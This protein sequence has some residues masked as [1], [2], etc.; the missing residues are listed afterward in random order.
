M[1]TARWT[2]GLA[3][4]VLMSL[5]LACDGGNPPTAPGLA[6]PALTADA[7][8]SA[9]QDLA[10]S[11]RRGT[12]MLVAGT[13]A[14]SFTPVAVRQADGNTFIDFNF[15]ERLSGSIS[16]TRTG[17][18]TLVIH[19]DGT[20]NVKDT[21]FLTGNLAGVSGS[22]NVEAWAQGTFASVRGSVTI[23]PQTG[24]GGFAGLQGVAKVTGAATGPAT[25]AGSYEGQVHF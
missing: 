16:G 1:N 3:G 18:G 8:A 22:V 21:G 17:T 11:S 23:Y 25:L 6:R 9:G 24:T 20:L 13:F 2:V 12:P 14:L 7:L 4:A 5:A 15:H 10:G 19:P